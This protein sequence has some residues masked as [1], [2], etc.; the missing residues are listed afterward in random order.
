ME[1]FQEYFEGSI[2]VKAKFVKEC[3]REVL[4]ACEL[5]V[6]AL[7]EGR[8]IFLFGNGGSAM[9]AQH[10]AA[11]LVN[12]FETERRPLPAIALGS[13]LAAVTSISNDYSFELVFQK[14]LQALA[15]AGDIA[16]GI[17]TSGK[18]PNVEKALKWARENG[19][20]T[21]G[22]LGKGGG[23]IKDLV[24]VSIIVPSNRTSFIQEVHITIGHFICSY[25]DNAFK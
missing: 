9:D 15:K 25:I 23:T 22:L 3:E 8:K 7:K 19:I 18:S 12:R 21:I 11:E 10:I 5:M 6:K 2:K 4:Q 17:S 20:L 1:S 24:D 14:P 16:I 13:N